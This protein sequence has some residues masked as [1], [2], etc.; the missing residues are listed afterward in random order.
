MPF[1]IPSASIH[2]RPAPSCSLAE[3]RMELQE[4]HFPRA[5]GPELCSLLAGSSSMNISRNMEF[6]WQDCDFICS[7]VPENP[8][9]FPL[10]FSPTVLIRCLGTLILGGV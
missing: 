7:S 4:D 3:G 1:S 5:Q 9:V 2:P 10:A 6:G 8:L